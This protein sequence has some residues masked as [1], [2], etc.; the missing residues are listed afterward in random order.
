MQGHD[1]VKVP[2]QTWGKAWFI[3]AAA[4]QV[5]VLL[6]AVFHNTVLPWLAFGASATQFFACGYFLSLA[7]YIC[8]LSVRDDA[9]T[10]FTERL[11]F[12]L[13]LLFVTEPPIAF[14]VIA[15]N[16]KILEPY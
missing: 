9:P 13:G 1:Q 2:A 16:I 11:A 12:A 7:G 10:K 4:I 3:G 14:M 5:I 8:G 6:A 15:L